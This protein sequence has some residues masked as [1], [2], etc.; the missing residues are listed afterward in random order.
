MILIIVIHHLLIIA[1]ALYEARDDFKQISKGE[2]IEH[3]GQFLVRVGIALLFTTMAAHACLKYHGASPWICASLLLACWPLFSLP[4]RVAL[5]MLRKEEWWYMGRMWDFR[6]KG[7][8]TYDGI[9][10]WMAWKMS[11]SKTHEGWAD[12]PERLPAIIATLTELTVFAIAR[13]W[14]AQ[15]M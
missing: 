8:A 14:M 2:Y 5:N 11:G 12:Y 1:Y 4:F 10:H 7:D 6:K 13:W 15:L 3:K 9:Y